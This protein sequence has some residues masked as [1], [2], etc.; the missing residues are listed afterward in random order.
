MSCVDRKERVFG[1]VQAFGQGHDVGV[2][3]DLKEKGRFIFL[4]I[5]LMNVIW[6]VILCVCVGCVFLSDGKWDLFSV[7]E[8]NVVERARKIGALH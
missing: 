4:P 8:V 2:S 3:D 7:L 6:R 1:V 5:W